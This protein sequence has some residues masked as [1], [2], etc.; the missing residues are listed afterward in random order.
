MIE[1]GSPEWLMQRCGKVTASRVA[2][3]FAETKSG[4]SASRKN[5]LAQ[6]AAERLTLTVEQ[7]F[8]NDAMRHGTEHEPIARALYEIAKGIAVDQV[9]FVNHPSIDMAGASPDGLVLDDGLVEFKCPNT[10]T[11]IEYMLSG[12][13]PKK[14]Q[15]QMVW[16]IICTER[17]WCDFVSYD[18]RMPEDLQLFIVRYRPTAEFKKEIEDGVK[19]FIKEVDGL[20]A[21]LEQIQQ[22]KKD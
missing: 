21:R 18:P 2:D 4:P 19:A 15:Y 20:V 14:Y 8:V 17:E 3:I 13:A 11:H 6:L 22:L 9:S 5:Y 12:D 7:S 10:A 1:Q 16:Q